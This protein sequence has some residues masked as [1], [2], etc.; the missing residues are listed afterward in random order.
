MI[1][2]HQRH[3]QTDRRTDGQTTCDRNTALCTKV[4]RAVKSKPYMLWS[5]FVLL[6]IRVALLCDLF[7]CNT[8]M[9]QVS[10]APKSSHITSILRS[11]HWLKINQHTEYKLLSLTYNVLT[12]SQPDYLHNLIS[13]QSSGRTHSSSAV[14]LARPCSIVFWFLLDCLRGSW[15]CTELS[16][17]WRLFV[18]VSG[19]VC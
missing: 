8:C 18:L 12:T 16:E 5:L 7:R 19:Y 11:L 9:S 4:H 14:T 13:V 6:Q 2:I 1:T 17:H 15:T 3:K 10:I